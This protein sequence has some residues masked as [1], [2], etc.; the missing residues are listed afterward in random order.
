MTQVGGKEEELMERAK[1]MGRPAVD[2][3]NSDVTMTPLDIPSQS[4]PEFHF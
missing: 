1:T 4:C 3:I 2:R